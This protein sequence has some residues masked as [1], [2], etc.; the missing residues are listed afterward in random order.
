MR[1]SFSSGAGYNPRSTGLMGKSLSYCFKCSKLIREEEFVKGKAFNLGDRVSCAACA[2]EVG[3]VAPRGASGAPAPPPPPPTP[4]TKVVVIREVAAPSPSRTPIAIGAFAVFLIVIGGVVAMT[5][6]TEPSAAP[7]ARPAGED[8]KPKR[9]EPLKLPEVRGEAPKVDAD[10]VGHWTLDEGQGNAIRD[11]SGCGVLGEIK[12]ATWTEGRLGNA[13]R[14]NGNSY[15]ELRNT[16]ALAALQ[17]N[18]YTIAL[19]F[20]S[21]DPLD[22]LKPQGLVMKPG[23]HEGLVVRKH[24]AMEHWLQDGTSVLAVPSGSYP[25][26]GRFYHVVGVVHRGQ[27]LVR[28]VVDGKELAIKRFAPGVRGME[29][30]PANWRIGAAQPSSGKSPYSTTG[31]ID[32]VRLYK[33]ALSDEEIQRLIPK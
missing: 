17:E 15:V 24:F 23:K 28:V 25:V 12:G 18:D 22:P 8:S 9:E 27:G 26:P 4:R 5:R 16:P 29:Y 11:S 13:L 33:R 21:E 3:A 31:I 2:R 7:P 6:T 32:D 30:G 10:L 1:I 14:F 19:W 20:R